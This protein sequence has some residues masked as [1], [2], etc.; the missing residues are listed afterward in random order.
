MMMM[1]AIIPSLTMIDKIAAWTKSILC[2]VMTVF[3]MK[4]VMYVRTSL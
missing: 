3:A 2:I 1:V 4:I